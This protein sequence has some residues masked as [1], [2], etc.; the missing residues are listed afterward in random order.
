[1]PIIIIITHNSMTMLIMPFKNDARTPKR[2]QLNELTDQHGQRGLPEGGGGEGE[3][4]DEDHVAASGAT[5]GHRQV[6]SQHGHG[7]HFLLR[8]A[9]SSFNKS[10]ALAFR[11][12][13]QSRREVSVHSTQRSSLYL[14]SFLSSYFQVI[15]ST[16]PFFCNCR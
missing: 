2:N 14:L 7:R 16:Q 1:M 6:L 15:S 12:P 5:S 13:R 3:K 4:D 10:Q 11:W 9:F 8:L